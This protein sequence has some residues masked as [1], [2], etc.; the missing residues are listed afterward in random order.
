MTTQSSSE[1]A[2]V[3]PANVRPT[4]I[5]KSTKKDD[6]VAMA[7]ELAA[8]H[9]TQTWDLVSLPI[10]KRVIVSRWVY[11]IKNKSYGSIERYKARLVAKGYAQEYGMDYEET[12]GLVAITT[13]TRTLIAVASSHK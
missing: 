13:T 2:A 7:E 3:P 5:R 10:G 8:L 1:V 4:R 9:Q 12:F 6:F 11:K